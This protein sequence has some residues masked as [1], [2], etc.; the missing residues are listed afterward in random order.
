VGAE[1]EPERWVGLVRNVML[2]REGLHRSVLMELLAAAGGSDPRSYLTTGNVTFGAA[3]NSEAKAIAG[4]LEV[5]IAALLGRDEMVAVRRRASLR[6]LIARNP[7]CDYDPDLWHLE[8]AFLSASAS[9]LIAAGFGDAGSTHI[10]E[11]G[12]REIFVA[13]PIDGPRGPHAN[14]LL[15][16]LAGGR[17]TSRGWPTLVRLAQDMHR[18]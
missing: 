3:N 17:A 4:R 14:P 11:V 10:V 6:D 2:G 18:M 12:Q 15:E 8:V 7:F 5:S 1:A 16:R 9:P 13:R